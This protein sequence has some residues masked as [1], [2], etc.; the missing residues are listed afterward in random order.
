MHGLRA[1]ADRQVFLQILFD[2]RNCLI[3]QMTRLTELPF[4]K[5]PAALTAKLLHPTA[6]FF[7]RCGIPVH[8][9]ELHFKLPDFGLRC[10]FDEYAMHSMRQLL[11]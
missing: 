1:L 7:E 2:I 8:V 10:T 11:A 3:D 4:L 5:I 9:G 6:N